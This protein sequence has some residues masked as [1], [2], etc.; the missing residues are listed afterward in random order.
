MRLSLA[1]LGQLTWCV[2]FV[3]VCAIVVQ[4]ATMLLPPRPATSSSLMTA[5]SPARPPASV[6]RVTDGPGVGQLTVQ[7][8]QPFSDARIGQISDRLGIDVIGAYPA[9]GTYLLKVP[10]IS[11]DT[12]GNNTATVFF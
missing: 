2:A 9:F 10:T 11:V 6:M 3:S 5:S 12:T 7:M 1:H 4:S 8:D